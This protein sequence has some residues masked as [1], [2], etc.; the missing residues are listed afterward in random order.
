MGII[1]LTPDSFYD[2]GSYPSG[3]G[4][5]EKIS[6]MIN[7]GASVID[8][9]ALSTRPGSDQLTAKEELERLIPSLIPIREAFP[10]VI[11]SVDTYR[12]EVA[13]AAIKAGADLIN[14]VSG[15]MMDNEMI[16]FMCTREEAY[17]IMHMQGT[18]E[19]MQVNPQYTDVVKEVEAFFMRQTAIFKKAGKHNII[20]DPGFGF[21]KNIEHNYKLLS[22]IAEFTSLCYPVLAGVSRKSMINRVLDIKAASALN[23]TTVINTIALLRGASIL[24]VHDVK[25]AVEAVRLFMAYKQSL[26]KP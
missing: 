18:P 15:G 17:I 20:L 5:L 3:E 2:G 4:L 14:D 8:I 23:G 10:E 11:L 22:A 13:E 25:E 16:P 7:E 1:N 24:R 19:N 9:G 6:V 26:M 12:K 21:G